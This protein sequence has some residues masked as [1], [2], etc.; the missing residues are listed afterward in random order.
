MKRLIAIAALFLLFAGMYSDSANAVAV[1][2]GGIP[3]GV[4]VT[5]AN[6]PILLA[7]PLRKALLCQNTGGTNPSYITFGQTAT[8]TNGF[9]LAPTAAT[10]N[11]NDISSQI[12]FPASNPAMQAVGGG[13]VPLG[14][15]NAIAT[16]GSTNVV[17]WED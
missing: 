16:G 6:T 9:L 4:T 13:A 5:T 7:N 14:A 12:S 10:A 1:A 3:V 2:G 17:C 11:V 15:V 8:A